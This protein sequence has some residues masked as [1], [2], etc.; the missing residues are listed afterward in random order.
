MVYYI[1][2]VLFGEYKFKEFLQCFFG[3]NGEQ[4]YEVYWLS[5]DIVCDDEDKNNI[6]NGVLDQIIYVLVYQLGLQGCF[7][8]FCWFYFCQIMLVKIVI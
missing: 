8:S 3:N 4:S 6:G 1:L 2:V 7:F 5:V